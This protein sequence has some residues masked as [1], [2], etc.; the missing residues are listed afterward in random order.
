MYRKYKNVKYNGY[1][2]KAEARRGAELEM[3]QRCGAISGLQKQVK[4]ILIPSQY[5]TINGKRKCLERPCTYVADF[6]Y[7]KNGQLIVEDVKGFVTPEFVI[8]RKLML[9]VY[10]IRV[11]EIKAKDVRK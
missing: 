1:D 5:G 8:K 10:G 6:V 2:S 3:L 11:H 4:Y 7:H 9:Q